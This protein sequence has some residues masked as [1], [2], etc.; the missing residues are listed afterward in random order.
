M[1]GCWD[2]T[3][4]SIFSREF[5]L[6]A[7]YSASSD[8]TLYWT[9]VQFDSVGVQYLL[10]FTVPIWQAATY[11]VTSGEFSGHWWL[12]VIL[13]AASQTL[14]LNFSANSK[15]NVTWIRSRIGFDWWKIQRSK[16]RATVHLGIKFNQTT[17]TNN[18]IALQSSKTFNTFS[19]NWIQQTRWF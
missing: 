6:T 1:T 16:S 2:L 11:I 18:N 3:H 7:T 19:Q 9:A 17:T 4:G 8:F 13:P 10:I 12:V 5:W 14:N 15:P